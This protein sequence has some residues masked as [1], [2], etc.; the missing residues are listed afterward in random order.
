MS[1]LS[2]KVTRHSEQLMTV[3]KLLMENDVITSGQKDKEYSDTDIGTMT[4]IDQE[5]GT[6][7][8]FLHGCGGYLAVSQEVEGAHFFSVPDG[9]DLICKNCNLTIAFNHIT[10]AWMLNRMK[11]IK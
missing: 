8:T 2:K 9:E 10:S 1:D 11:T 5:C 7:T 3:H 6:F 4:F